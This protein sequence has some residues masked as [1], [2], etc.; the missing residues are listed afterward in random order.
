MTIKRPIHSINVI[1]NYVK[2]ETTVMCTTL[3][4]RDAIL[5]DKIVTKYKSTR[6]SVLRAIL[7]KE[8]RGKGKVTSLVDYLSTMDVK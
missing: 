8:L 5:L 2:K 6:A 3:L 4:D 1:G 7:L